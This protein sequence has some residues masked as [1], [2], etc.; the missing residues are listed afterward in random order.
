MHGLTCARIV[1]ASRVISAQD[2]RRDLMGKMAKP[3][4]RR[5]ES[6]LWYMRLRVPRT[7]RQLRRCTGTAD[8]AEAM[9]VWRKAQE[10]L[11]RG[12]PSRTLL[13][14][15]RLYE[16]VDTNP[17]YRQAR[18]E[19]FRYG[20]EYA[21]GVAGSMRRLE[22]ILSRKMPRLL[23]M[24]SLELTKPDALAVR[25]AIFSSRGGSRSS[26]QMWSAFRTMYS[27]LVAEALIDWNPCDGLRG[28]AHKSAPRASFPAD[29]IVEAIARPEI[30]PTHDAWAFFAFTAYTG[31]RESEVLALKASQLDGDVLTVDSALK[32]NRMSDVGLP[33]W[34]LIRTIPLSK[35]AM[36]VLASLTP[37]WKGRYFPHPRS[38]AI[39]ACNAARSG[40]CALFPDQADDYSRMTCHT[41]RH[42]MNTNL[43][44][45]KQDPIMVAE[46][47]SWEHQKLPDIQ[48]RYTHIYAESMRVIAD[49]IDRIYAPPRL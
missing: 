41:L 33:K 22:A 28:I 26:Q 23:Q 6:E 46:Y 31:M 42:S 20:K 27:Q 37:D 17:R 43:L 21:K 25:E 3:L 9:E 24:D 49:T 7:G 48:K 11:E 19:G 5:A 47:L 30:F 18:K 35:L 39:T 15:M 34:D 13:E 2:G 38:W 14:L 8:E 32:G 44:V 4:Y 12:A 16:S 45:A 1:C 40:M 36:G 29:M 10:A